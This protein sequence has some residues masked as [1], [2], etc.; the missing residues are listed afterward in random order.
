MVNAIEKRDMVLYLDG[1]S[2]ALDIIKGCE[3]QESNL[4]KQTR[5][6]TFNPSYMDR[7]I[8]ER[9]KEIIE[10]IVNLRKEQKDE[11]AIDLSDAFFQSFTPLMNV[12][13]EQKNF[14][15]VCS[16]WNWLIS[17]V[18]DIEA[19]RRVEFGQGLHKGTAFYFLG[20]SMLMMGD[21]D[22][23]YLSFSEAA[24]EDEIL[25][26]S[27]LDRH[28]KGLPPVVKI[29]LLDLSE[30]NFAYN[31]VRQI[32]E[33]VNNWEQQYP[34]ISR[35]TSTFT[36]M[37]NAID[38]NKMPR[39]TAIHLCYAFTKA[40]VLDF[41]RKGFAR[42]TFLTIT[43]MGESVL[44]FARTLEDFIR[45]SQNL[46]KNA[47]IFDYCHDQWFTSENWT[48][49]SYED[50]IEGLISDFLNNKWK[51]SKD[52]RNVLFTLKI[53]TALAHR[54]PNDQEIFEKYI[55]MI[56]ATSGSFGFVC[57]KISV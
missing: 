48:V 53:R 57:E 56:L 7:Q 36:S 50:D 37:Q 22:K 41:W 8:D 1:N 28:Q 51:L 47:R 44:R 5:W 3:F 20:F 13:V 18:R 27:V 12:L 15:Q 25:P 14:Y 30:D 26:Q 39:E 46:S 6:L 4:I 24:K 16:M 55:Q 17:K 21:V 40:F 32:R 35:V 19:D 43:Q 2:F 31:L 49:S 9:I 10:Y 23:A 29:L 11:D 45:V 33:T 42:P 34:G 54:I 52:G 38:K